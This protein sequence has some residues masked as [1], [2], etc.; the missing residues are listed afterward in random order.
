MSETV[1]TRMTKNPIT[2]GANESLRTAVELELQKKI[3]H[4]PIVDAKGALV[5]ILTDRDIKRALPSPVVH[6]DEDERERLLDETQLARIMTRDPMTVA[7]GTPV[8]EAVRSML[9]KKVGGLPVVE[10]GKLVGIFTQGDALRA[11]LERL[12]R[13]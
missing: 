1:G 7:P 9:A 4:I 10:N 13:E 12:E 3:R 6:L 11:Y 2:L 5:G 8:A